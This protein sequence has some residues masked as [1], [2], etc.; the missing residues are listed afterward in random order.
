[1]P[2]SRDK[3]LTEQ[4]HD[5]ELLQLA[6]KRLSGA[7][8]ANTISFREVAAQNGIDLNALPTEDVALE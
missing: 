2:P 4:I 5:A 7:S 6:E 3:D 8:S 1:M